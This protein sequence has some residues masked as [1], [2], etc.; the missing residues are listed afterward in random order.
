MGLRL[1]EV[2]F[3]FDG[4]DWTLRCNMSVLM[5]VQEA[6]GGSFDAILGGKNHTKSCLQ[7]LSAMLN[8]D[9]LERG[10]DVTYTPRQVG[11][12]LSLREF[13]RASKLVTDLLVSALRDE[14]A[15]ESA[16]ADEKN[17]KTSQ[18]NDA[19]FPSAGT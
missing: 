16:E 19:A 7:L 4:L 3:R 8:D 1:K 12:K 6:N 5:D 11:R 17:A 14:D 2:P 9:A 18:A 15:P 13:Q 10:R